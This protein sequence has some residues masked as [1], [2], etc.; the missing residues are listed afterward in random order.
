MRRRCSPECSPSLVSCIFWAGPGKWQ[1]NGL[2]VHSTGR[3]AVASVAGVLREIGGLGP[4]AWVLQRGG[5]AEGLAGLQ[6]GEPGA[7]EPGPADGAGLWVGLA[8]FNSSDRFLA[9]K[10]ISAGSSHP[11]SA[12]KIQ[13]STEKLATDPDPCFNENSR[14]MASCPLTG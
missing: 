2:R 4:A 13:K 9:N 11:H 14:F 3:V 12:A 7:L 10:V 8:S 6:D 5:G 1:R